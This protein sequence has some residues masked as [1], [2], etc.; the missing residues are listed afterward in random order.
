MPLGIRPPHLVLSLQPTHYQ[1]NVNSSNRLDW[2]CSEAAYV[3]VYENNA[4]VL[5]LL[6]KAVEGICDLRLFC[7]LIHDEE[8]PLRFWRLRN[9][10]DAS[11]EEAS[12]RVFIA[13]HCNE[14]PI[15]GH[16]S[17]AQHHYGEGLTL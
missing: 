6:R 17:T 14:L 10:S 13:Y 16:L 4:N 1:L 15:L 12:D 9:M 3:L 8:V 2:L 11:E 7:L 5:S